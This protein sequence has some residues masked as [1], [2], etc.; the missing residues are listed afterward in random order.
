[1]SPCMAKSVTSTLSGLILKMWRHRYICLLF[2]V[3]SQLTWNATQILRSIHRSTVSRYIRDQLD[4]L[5][6]AIN[7]ALNSELDSEDVEPAD[8]ERV[9][10][11]YIGAKRKPV[12][13]SSLEEEMREDN[14]FRNFRTRFA[15][16]LS[17]FLPTYGHPLPGPR[18]IPI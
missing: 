3:V 15:D 16:F 5:D 12:S 9:D 6:E 2:R 18:H 4:Y 13:F 8:L 17:D 10:N 14:A 7:N 11:V 1:M